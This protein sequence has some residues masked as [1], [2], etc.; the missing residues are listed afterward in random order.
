MSSFIPLPI[1]PKQFVG[2]QS[3][4]YEFIYLFMNH[5]QLLPISFSPTTQKLK[6]KQSKELIKLP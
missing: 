6:E 4:F 3:P 5:V 1:S 2:I